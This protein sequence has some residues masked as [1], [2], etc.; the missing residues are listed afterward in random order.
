METEA[1][2][3]N[4]G[5]EGIRVS[6]VSF[7]YSNGCQ[8]LH[9]V[10]F[11]IDSE[12]GKI[13]GL[14][15]PNGAGKTTLVSILSTVFKKFTGEAYICGLDA[16]KHYQSIRNL[17]SIAP[18]ELIIDALLT[19]SDNLFIHGAVDGIPLHLLRER[20]PPLLKEVNLWDKR[21][22]LAINLSGGQMRRLQIIRALLKREAKVFFIDEPTIGLDPIGKQVIWRQLTELKQESKLVFLASNDMVE[23]E[24][25]CDEIIFIN[26][27]E[28]LFKGTVDEAKRSFAPVAVID[29][30]FE[31]NISQKLIEEMS[32]KCPLRITHIH[33]TSKD[34]DFQLWIDQRENSLFIFLEWC[35]SQNLGVRK[36]RVK[37]STLEEVFYS[38]AKS[39]DH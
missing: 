30:E 13:V 32:G 38:L 27:G 15:G 8:A 9:D 36:A 6:K 3:D 7:T 19:V 23:V 2:K 25:L 18:Q 31:D 35:K 34:Q 17:I 21:H 10:S 11:S 22:Q 4:G 26:K 39:E 33:P 29:V 20:I 14:L 37:E 28:I 5:S 1:H 16:K 24:K 12:R